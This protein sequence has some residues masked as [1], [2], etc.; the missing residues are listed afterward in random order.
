MFPW[1]I[2][3]DNQYDSVPSPLHSAPLHPSLPWLIL[4]LYLENNVS[5]LFVIIVIRFR[6]GLRQ[7][8]N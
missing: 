7:I 6:V 5:Y 4:Q 2:Y 8:F 3:L 1:L